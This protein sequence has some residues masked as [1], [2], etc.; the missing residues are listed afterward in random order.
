MKICFVNLASGYSGGENQTFFLA[1]E[2]IKNN[3]DIVAV[4]NPKSLL[5][6]KLESLGIKT[7]PSN[8][9]LKGH[10][11]PLLRDLDLIHAHDGKAVHWASLHKAIFKSPF[12]VT[13]R[14]DNPIRDNVIT[15]WSYAQANE[16]IGIS[17]K[18][19]SVLSDF[20]PNGKK[21]ELIPSSPIAYE[22]S[23]VKVAKE[24][25]KYQGKFI[26]VQA[27]SLL[28]HK[29]FDTT[30]K[31]ARLL[32]DHNIIFLFLGE[33][34]YREHL[35][36]LAN[37][38][39]NVLFL[40]KQ[41]DMGNWF[42]IADCLILPSK[43]EGLGSVIL[44]AM[45]AGTP[46]IASKVGG[47]PDLVKNHK[48]GLLISPGREEQLASAIQ[49]LIMNNDLKIELIKNAKEF[50]KPFFI[51]NTAQKYLSIYKKIITN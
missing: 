39:N 11:H 18:I 7:I 3:V 30:I 5:T 10:F 38:L 13:R 36:K 9:P 22:V 14:I 49:E 40:G 50:I 37:G 48:T 35:M 45:L 34:P 19:C 47:I 51:E 29:G 6:S 8:H 26:V 31:T 28:E 43:N 1:K 17:S 32:K 44:E 24:R 41:N 27:A 12:V 33:G 21:I 20:V 16:L 2:L 42:E 15:H 4:T 23:P 46:V 25:S